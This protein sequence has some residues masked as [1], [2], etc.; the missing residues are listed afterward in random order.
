MQDVI[1][2][3]VGVNTYWEASVKAGVAG[4]PLRILAN[5]DP[6]ATP[7]LMVGSMSSLTSEE[8]FDQFVASNTGFLGALESLD[9]HGWSMLAESPPGHVPIRVLAS[10]A[11]V[12]H[13]G[14]RT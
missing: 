5:F 14:A 7:K 9:D 11:L 12:G 8:V 13:V 10:H 6:A 4:E 1:A 3:I 2:H